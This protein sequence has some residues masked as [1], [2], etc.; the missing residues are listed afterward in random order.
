MRKADFSRFACINGPLYTFAKQ[1][2]ARCPHFPSRKYSVN[3]SVSRTKNRA[4]VLLQ[5]IKPNILQQIAQVMINVLGCK[6]GSA[7][8]GHRH[9]PRRLGRLLRRVELA[10]E[11]VREPRPTGGA[12]RRSRRTSGP[13]ARDL[14]VA[15][16]LERRRD[17]LPASAAD[18]DQPPLNLTV[19]HLARK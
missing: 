19:C 12:V 6:R 1:T 8:R 2:T 16:Q 9:L 14:R 18:T 7:A 17:S 15:I 4:E 3:P 11:V 13:T 10:T 5:R